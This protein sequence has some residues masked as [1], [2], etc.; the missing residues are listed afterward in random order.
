MTKKILILGG[1]QSALYAARE[2][3]RNDEEASITIFGEEK[4]LP[5][6]RPP[7][8]K[9]FLLNKKNEEDLIFNS[10]GVLEDKKINYINIKI[11][12]VDFETKTLFSHNEKKFSYDILLITNGS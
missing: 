5:Y 7:L 8:S 11:E 4:Q 3:R 12:K 2:I 6:E 9:D 10:S 1:G